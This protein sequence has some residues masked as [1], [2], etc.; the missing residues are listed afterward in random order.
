MP[1]PPHVMAPTTGLAVPRR[2]STDRLLGAARLFAE[3][4]R[5]R[6]AFLRNLKP[7][8]LD[9]ELRSLSLEVGKVQGPAALGLPAQPRHLGTFNP[10][11]A[12]AP[13]GLC[14]RCAFVVSVRVDALHQCDAS[15]PY[16][17]REPGM[18]R[19]LA[20]NAWFKGTAIALLDQ[21]LQLLTWTWL[22]SS[23]ALQVSRSP[24]Q[25]RQGYHAPLGAAGNFSTPPWSLRSYDTRL[26]NFDGRRVF[27]TALEPC[28]HSPKHRCAGQGQAEFAVQ[29]LQLTAEAT[30]SGGATALRAWLTA[31]APSSARWM[32]GRNQALF[33]APAAAWQAAAGG[34]AAG[35]AA[36]AAGAGPPRLMAQPWLG[37][38]ALL[39]APSFRNETVRCHPRSTRRGATA[40]PAARR[41]Q[42]AECA[43][44]PRDATA[45]VH[46]VRGLTAATLAHNETAALA[47]RLGLGLGGGLGGLGGAL[48]LRQLS[49]T[50][51]LLEV[52]RGKGARRCSA[53]LGVGHTHRR[54]GPLLRG[55]GLGRRRPTGR[56][57]ASAEAEAEAPS[58]FQFGSEYTHFFYTLSPVPPHT[59]LATSAEFCVGAAQAPHDCESVQF[60]AGLALQAGARAALQAGQP[61]PRRG[62]TNGSRLVLSLGVNDCEAKLGLVPMQRVWKLLQPLPPAEAP[63][64]VN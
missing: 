25:V 20:A 42:L 4:G 63:C 2:Y 10:S 46:K 9:A 11:I 32:Q 43:A 35:G 21:R 18:P 52:S 36:D 15:S 27:V 6:Q 37:L 38:V 23:P 61:E 29:L 19:V 50:T 26:F 30:A 54:D 16:S 60:I 3:S 44:T 12:A 14:P 5:P 51:G 56:R 45:T 53:L 59:L 7:I 62:R 17:R 41:Q 24:V 57:G 28:E 48:P 31:R 22:L 49:T 33:R 34:V 47:A 8:V 39:G 55:R 58:P 1:L 40:S 64:T 13:R